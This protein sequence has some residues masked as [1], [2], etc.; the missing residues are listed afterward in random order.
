MSENNEKN[1]KKTDTKE[2]VIAL[3]PAF[4]ITFLFLISWTDR[5]FVLKDEWYEAISIVDSAR[6][7]EDPNLKKE[8]LDRGGKWLLELKEKYPFHAKVRMF[9][10]YYYIQAGKFDEAIEELHSAIEQGKGGIVNQIEFQA[11]DFLTNALANK[12]AILLQQKKYDEAIAVMEKSQPYAPEHP[13]FLNQF[14]SVYSQANKINK[15]IEYLEKIIKINPNYGKVREQLAN[16]YFSMGNNFA[17]QN[18]PNQAYPSY[19][20]AVELVQTNPHYYNNLANIELQ[21]NKVEEAI[22]HFK[23]AVSLDPKNKTFK[24]NLKIAENKLNNP[25]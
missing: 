25:S 10:G 5:D 21:L 11:R 1:S 18:I 12:T 7:I 16:I 19:K 13:S 9:V 15:A 2:I 8:Y 14:A 22:N 20:R 6:S 24:G 4:I 23:K 17:R 3:I